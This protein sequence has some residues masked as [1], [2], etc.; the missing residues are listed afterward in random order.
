MRELTAY[1]REMYERPTLGG[2]YP[3]N[4]RDLETVDPSLFW[5]A[6]HDSK[7]IGLVGLLLNTDS[8][9]K[10]IGAVVDPIIVT[11]EFRS[12]GI[13]GR[14]LETAVA[15][16]RAREA[17]EVAIKHLARNIKTL[18][19]SYK[20]G[21]TYVGDIELFMPLSERSRKPGPRIYEC[22]FNM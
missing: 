9:S 20:H 7:L 16:A 5:V 3:P 15:E 17:T 13:G 19:F 11:R 8:F 6:V 18:Q 14:L 10:R 1:H 2:E 21:F 4:D 22:D 12:K